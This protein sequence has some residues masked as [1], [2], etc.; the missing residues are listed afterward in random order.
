MVREVRKGNSCG[1][2][3]YTESIARCSFRL[4]ILTGVGSLF[5]CMDA[6]CKR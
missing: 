3:D 4:G 5:L 2:E 6:Q 1:C